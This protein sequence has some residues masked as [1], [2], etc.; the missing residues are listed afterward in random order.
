MLK[1]YLVSAWR[2]LFPQA[3]Y[4]LVNIGAWPSA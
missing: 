2:N 3:A 4:S 1:N